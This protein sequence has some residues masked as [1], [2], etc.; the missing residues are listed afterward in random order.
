MRML[1]HLA[2]NQKQG[3]I[4]ISTIAKQ[5]DIPTEYA[6]K[7]I[8]KLSA[9]KI[10][11]SQVGARGGVM[12]NKDLKSIT[13]HSIV[14]IIQGPVSISDCVLNPRVCPRNPECKFS[15]RWS[16]IQKELINLLEATTLADILMDP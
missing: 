9:A 12:L 15:P 7:I 16:A 6:Y 3:F 4:S 5:Q 8:R 2:E 13:L 10:T 11:N 1:A 14:E